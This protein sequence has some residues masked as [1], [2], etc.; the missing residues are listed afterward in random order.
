ML[1][2]NVTHLRRVLTFV[3]RAESDAFGTP[4]EP[5]TRVAVVGIINNPLAGRFVEDLEPLFEQGRE[6]GE[7]LVEAAL[8][9]LTQPAVS[10][11]KAAIVGINGEM[12]HGGAMIHPRLGAV[13]REPIGGGDAVIPSNVK[14]APMGAQIDV[15]LGHKDNACSFDHFD[16]FTISLPDGPR[17]DEIA[18]IV[19][20]ADGGR[21]HARC[22]S[23]PQK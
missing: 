4:C 15:P 14:V 13:M 9:Q 18:M 3:D 19:S 10:Y 2:G 8:K 11:G 7:Q 12:E 22:G 17:P 16:T 6:V 23:G 20:F 5:I 21:V 1:G